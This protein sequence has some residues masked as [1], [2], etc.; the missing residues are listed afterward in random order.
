LLQHTLAQFNKSKGLTRL[1]ISGS[2]TTALINY[3]YVLPLSYLSPLTSHLSPLTSHLSPLTSHLSPLTSQLSPLTSHLSPL[4]SHLSP[5]T[6]H[7]SPLTSHLSSL[8]SSPLSSHLVLTCF[9]TYAGMFQAQ[10]DLYSLV[11]AASNLQSIPVLDFTG[12]CFSDG[13]SLGW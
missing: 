4:T 1:T 10:K 5:L 12:A 9:K 6:S 7:L 2:H 8:L 13:Q 3:R 11:R